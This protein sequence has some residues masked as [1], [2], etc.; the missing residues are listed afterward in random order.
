MENTEREEIIAVLR[1]IREN[2]SLKDENDEDDFVV[3]VNSDRERMKDF[4]PK[5]ELIYKMEFHGY[6]Q[7]KSPLAFERELYYKKDEHGD[8]IIIRKPEPAVYFY[9]V[10]PKGTEL[11]KTTK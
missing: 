3:L 7:P 1:A 11:L 10:A 8:I 4:F 9:D 6:I 5:K 2:W